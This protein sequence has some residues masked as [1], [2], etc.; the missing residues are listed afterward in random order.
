VLLLVV[1]V[2]VGGGGGAAAIV[3]TNLIIA[4]IITVNQILAHQYAQSLLFLRLSFRKALNCITN[5]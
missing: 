5:G 3:V 1:V 2:V 4:L